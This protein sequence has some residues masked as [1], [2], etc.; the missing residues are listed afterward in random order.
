MPNHLIHETSPY[1]LQHARQ[2]VDWFP[3][4]AAALEKARVEGRPIFLSIGY[5]ACHW[6]HVMAHESFDDPQ[7]GQFLN[8]HFVSVKVDREER[9]DLDSIYMSSVVAMTG[10]GGWPM[11]LFITP[12]G[13]PFYGGTYFPP[14]SAYG[15]PS[16]KQVIES[17]AELWEKDRPEVDRVADQVARHIR[18]SAGVAQEAGSIEPGLLDRAASTLLASF[19]AAT[20]GWGTSPKFPQPM[21]IDFLFTQAARGNE[22]ALQAGIRSLEAMA[23]GGMY[24]L[25]GGGFHRYS[26]DAVWRT[27]HFEK[28]LYDNAQLAR[29]YLH[30]C[31][32]TGRQ[33]FRRVCEA[34]LE[35]MLRELGHA[36]GGFYSS[37]D[38]DSPGG[39]GRF[40]LWEEVEF[41]SAI[42]DPQI[43]A[44][45]RL[46]YQVSSQGSFE[47]LNILR[48]ADDLDRVAGDLGIDREKLESELQQANSLLAA[49]RSRR[50]RPPRDDKV[51]ACWNG[52]A[53]WAFAECG[54]AFHEPRYL[55]A[56]TR[57]ARFLLQHLSA[58][59]RLLRS[60]RSGQASQPAFLEDYGAVICGLLAL[61]KA[62]QDPA[63]Y[64][65]AEKLI[66]EMLDL[67]SE[68]SG[69][70]FDTPKDQNPL[71]VRP[72]DLQDNA[73]PSGSALAS[74]ALLKW[75]ELSGRTEGRA[76]IERQLGSIQPAAVQY[77]SA[78]SFWLQAVDFAVGPV[79]Q[80][81][82]LGDP[83][84]SGFSD[85]VDAY[86][87]DYRPR[88][89]LAASAYP[90]PG[91]SPALLADRPLS[92]G[93][94]TAYICQQFTCR[95][96]VS[97]V[98]DFRLALAHPP[99][100]PPVPG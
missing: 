31:Q 58:G 6:C 28:M 92:G 57:T 22:S 49:A 2:P 51:I 50:E 15:L 1:L 79:E 34:A 36:E 69:G 99:G 54:A 96:P 42:Q 10:Q 17:M 71:L 53:V 25:I 32:L 61:Y 82:I 7:I 19:D 46:T 93:Q 56:A 24:D 86:W 83:G 87:Q 23:Q 62:R 55:E 48:K 63:W 81:A 43:L 41:A 89:V 52:L 5:A 74:Y 26:T 35:F 88:A 73:T 8:Q 16:F 13:R 98:G 70:F 68:V 100:T 97:R 67:F 72:R 90:P 21:A 38:A 40:Y 3:W 30:G 11:S 84:S 45:A 4:G 95:M 78:F 37:L 59:G 20:G 33:D 27:P 76:K 12:D 85:L 9:P 94:P 80:V 64:Q 66:R 77:P 75:I 39:E 91:G 18:Q 29:A 60:W 47:G 44:A 14:Q 65:A